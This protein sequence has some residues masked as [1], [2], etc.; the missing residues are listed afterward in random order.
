MK[1]FPKLFSLDFFPLFEYHTAVMKKYFL[2]VISIALLSCTG[3]ISLPENFNE[4]YI[5]V[6]LIIDKSCPFHVGFIN[7]S[8]YYSKTTEE[9]AT[10]LVNEI[11]PLKYIYERIE[12]NIKEIFKNTGFKINKIIKQDLSYLKSNYKG[13]DVRKPLILPEIDLKKLKAE[14]KDNYVALFRIRFLRLEFDVRPGL[15]NVLLLN[16]FLLSI[17]FKTQRKYI[18]GICAYPCKVKE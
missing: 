7:P 13:P 18:F 10:M 2:V 4:K 1:L 12:N 3:K 6:T 8:Y 11:S 14:I 5:N 17:I 15:N 9:N 16:P